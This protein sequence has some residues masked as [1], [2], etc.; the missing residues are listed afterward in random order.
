MTSHDEAS[1][2]QQLRKE[3]AAVRESERH[4]RALAEGSQDYIFI[5]DRDDRVLYVNPAAAALFGRRP[6]EII[7]RRRAE[8]FPPAAAASQ[9]EDLRRAFET[10]EPLAAEAAA[11]FPDGERW[12]STVLIPVLDARG[13]ATALVGYSRDITDH[14]HAE[15]ELE[16]SRASL[17]AAVAERT[18]ELTRANASL[19][20]QVRARA[21]AERRQ[22]RLTAGLR[23]VLAAAGELARCPDADTLCRRAVELARERLGL[24]RC[25]L[26]LD[27]GDHLRGT[28]GTDRQGRTTEEHACRITKD[29][30]W[31][32]RFERFEPG[33]PRY[34][35][36]RGPHHEW[37]GERLR[38]VGQGWVAFTPIE[39][40]EAL[41]GAFYNDTAVSGAPPDELGQ[42]IAALYC[43]MLGGLLERKRAEDAL[44]EASAQ[45]ADFASIINRGPAIAFRWRVAQG[46]PVE[47][48]SDNVSQLGYTVDDLVSGRVSWPAITHPDDVARLEGEVGGRLRDGVDEFSQHYR[49]R[50]A[51]G[52]WRWI[53]D[54]NLVIRDARGEVA[55]IEGIVLDVTE[56]KRAEDALRRARDELER[57]VVERTAELAEANASLRRSEERY[58]RLVDNATVGV[59]E[60]SLTGEILYVNDALVRIFGL[61][62]REAFI[63]QGLGARYKRP[64]DRLRLLEA[65]QRTG[66]VT[67]FETEVNTATGATKHVLISAVLAGDVLTGMISDI[68]ERKRAEEELRLSE[69]QYR[70]TVNAL[71]DSLHVVDRELRILL[72]NAVIH[73]WCEQLGLRQ[74]PLGRRLF[75]A[76][77]FLDP[78]VRDEYRQ[79]FETGKALATEEAYVFDGREV[80]TETRKIPVFEEAEVVRVVTLIRDITEE[81][82]VQE[83]MRR[84]ERLESLGVLAGG[85]AHDFSNLL[86]GILGSLTRARRALLDVPQTADALVQA[87]RAALRARG[88]TRQLLALSTGG[89]PI[90]AVAPIG[91][92]VR[93]TADF[94]LSGSNCRCQLAIATDLWPVEADVAQLS[95]VIQNLV[96]NAGQAMA[97]GGIVEVRARNVGPGEPTPLHGVRH[98]EIAIADAGVGIPREHHDRIFDPYFTTKEAGSGLGLAVCHSIVRQHGGHVRVESQAGVG[99]T[100][101]VYL[102]AADPEGAR[103]LEERPAAAARAG[104]VLLMDDEDVVRKTACWL[105]AD[106]GYQV[107]AAEHGAGAVELYQQ[108]LDDAEPFDVVILDLTVPGGMGGEECLRRLR[109]LDPGVTAI[110][111]SG[112]STEAVLSDFRRYGFAG[113]VVKPYEIEDLDA[114]LQRLLARDAS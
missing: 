83:E 40:D 10:G 77:P 44:R 26:F 98:L 109:E 96:I 60:T 36:L 39:S 80:I 20:E 61:E 68:T 57:R 16:E 94:A 27:E 21:E 55:A 9:S 99:T 106:L 75:D 53:E 28:Y 32:K 76:F 84:A 91:G 62:S 14:K 79:V 11:A 54:R 108:A 7:G 100:V 86:T 45:L 34:V 35:L 22:G 6:A 111:C 69:R 73:S 110:V 42:E 8:F 66:S 31:Q 19:R 43:S 58:R 97:D 104:R 72:H 24:E 3:L 113:A 13:R 2:A 63:A 78:R 41:L 82:K 105:L 92:M 93:E 33:G 30:Q 112:Y 38:V 107:A 114:E 47:F 46:W 12:L 81:R 52:E 50:T 103:E 67:N 5:I 4:Y 59:Y 51:S 88:I 95:E 101:R 71:G 17:E 18:A 37:D 90:K 25:S 74:D 89:A 49:L 29:A 70:S 87:Q 1:A 102:P 85:I 56:R 23:T 65:V 48:V 64:A 15:Q